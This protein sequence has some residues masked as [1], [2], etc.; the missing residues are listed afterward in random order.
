MEATRNRWE[1]RAVRPAR[2]KSWWRWMVARVGTLPFQ[3][4]ASPS[5]KFRPSGK[6]PL[7]GDPPA[8]EAA[9]ERFRDEAR[10]AAR[11]TMRW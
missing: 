6:R 11:E 3:G 4:E 10:A 2:W 9:R 1:W 5:G 7:P 8:A